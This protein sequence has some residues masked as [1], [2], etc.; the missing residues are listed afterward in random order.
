MPHNQ[1][2]LFSTFEPSGDALAAGVIARLKQ[3]RPDL[4]VY[5]LGGPRMAAAGAVVIEQTTQH[6]AM[7][8]ETVKQAWA[9]HQRLGRL[10]TWLKDHRIDMLVP[11]DSPAANW[12][13]CAAV[14]K[15]QPHA[16]IVHLVMP[17]LWAWGSWR[18][19]RLRRLTDHVLC[20]L[21]F[22]PDWLTIRGVEGTFVGHPVFDPACHAPGSESEAKSLPDAHPRLALLPGSRT[23]EIRK[24]W[25]TMLDTFALLKARHPQLE[26]VVAALDDRLSKMIQDIA[27]E[28]GRDALWSRGLTLAIGQTPSVLRWSDAVLVASGTATLQVAAMGKPMVAMYNASWL[29]YQFAKAF[30]LSTTTFTLPNLIGEGLKLGRVIPEFVPHHGNPQPLADALTPLLTNPVAHTHQVNLLRQ[31]A[32]PFDGK[33]FS[34]LSA[35]RLLSRLG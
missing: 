30:L 32:A 6:A 19:R 2:M 14:R 5:A 33:V 34:H 8:L 27:R 12:S 18:I 17:Q 21:P 11:V 23:G 10:N 31:V 16:G 15:Q 28:R 9:H 20:L 3:L 29:G 13:I 35:E 24:N 1:V 22:E 4:T 25:G 26:A 7:S